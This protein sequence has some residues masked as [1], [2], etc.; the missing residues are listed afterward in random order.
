MKTR[1]LPRKQLSA[2]TRRHYGFRHWAIPGEARCDHGALIV[3][4][5]TGK[6]KT[7]TGCEVGIFRRRIA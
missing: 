7:D 6:P 5:A 3:V 1:L 2:K 4:Q